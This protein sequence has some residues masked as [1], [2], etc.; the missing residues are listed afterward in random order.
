M[1]SRCCAP[2]LKEGVYCAIQGVLPSMRERP[3]GRIVNISSVVAED[4]LRGS[5]W[6]SMV[7]ASLHGLTR[8]LSRE[9]G[10][11]GILVNSVMPGLT[12]TDHIRSITLETRRRVE[13]NSPPRR[14]LTPEEV[15]ATVVFLSS[16]MNSSVTGEIIR[17]GGRF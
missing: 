2:T 1:G 12:D 16:A 15:A 6:Y 13:E 8:T 10:P 5:G 3:G 7:K 4:G 17:I 9:L 14:V 11:A